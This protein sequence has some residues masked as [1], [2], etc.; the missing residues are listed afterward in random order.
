[1]SIVLGIDTAL[2]QTSISL[3]DGAR[4]LAGKHV[5]ERES[6][7]SML[8]SWVEAVLGDA[9]LWYSDVDALSVAIGPGGFT[10]IRVGLA[11]ARGIA[12][13]AN[14]PLY[15][16]STMEMM[17]FARGDGVVVAVLP[18]GRGMVF[19]QTFQR[20]KPYDEARMVLQE[21]VQSLACDSIVTTIENLDV[22]CPM[23]LYDVSRS[24]Y[25]LCQLAQGNGVE[26]HAP[27][28]LYIRPPDAKLPTKAAF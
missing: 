1:M 6:Q 8:L 3:C 16:F 18:A 22:T 13:A 15:G 24:A 26:T 25:V 12:L 21:D 23:Q 7:A 19:T 28:P 4:E 10:G 9:G 17:A 11:A 27:T 14:K 2:G 20:L 5:F